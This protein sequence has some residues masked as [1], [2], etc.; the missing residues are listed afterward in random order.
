MNDGSNSSALTLA[1]N[2]QGY[3][4]PVPI[5]PALSIAPDLPL[6]ELPFTQEQQLGMADALLQMR[7]RLISPED[8]NANRSFLPKGYFRQSAIA[9]VPAVVPIQGG[10]SKIKYDYNVLSNYQYFRDGA[11]LV[12]SIGRNDQDQIPGTTT[13]P[14]VYI[15]RA[16][17]PPNLVLG[18]ALEWSSQFQTSAPM[19][20]KI[21]TFGWKGMSYQS[22]DRNVEVRIGGPGSLA[23]ANGGILAVLFAQRM[24]AND[25]CGYDSGNNQVASAEG[26]MQQAIVQPAWVPPYV[27]QATFDLADPPVQN[28]TT[29]SYI[30]G[31][32]LDSI[33]DFPYIEVTVPAAI[34]AGFSVL[35][36]YLT[37][38]SPQLADVRAALISG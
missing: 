36:R 10:F 24:S 4:R 26:G 12:G 17:A 29:V 21:Q 25:S 18:F 37:A 30:P 8:A 6:P 15:V 22:V 28:G 13:V 3:M 23:N 7:G 11:A 20:M 5:N 19:T 33:N 16:P 14:G 1:A 27:Q 34:A 2:S 38:A 35:G 31:L 32:S 9:A